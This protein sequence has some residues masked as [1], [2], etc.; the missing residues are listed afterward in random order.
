[1]EYTSPWTG[2]EL[3]TL[4]V[5][6][7]DCT[8]NRVWNGAKKELEQCGLLSAVF[9]IDLKEDTEKERTETLLDMLK[10]LTA[11]SS[12]T[13]VILCH[14]EAKSAIIKAGKEQKDMLGTF[15]KENKFY[16]NDRFLEQNSINISQGNEA[17]T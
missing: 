3:T 12:S 6:G 15:I 10:T 4:V 16:Y 8:E 1:M 14:R 5:I 17:V 11:K 13:E 7:T 9:L 2:F